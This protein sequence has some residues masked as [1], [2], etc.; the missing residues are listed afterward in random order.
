[1]HIKRIFKYEFWPFWLF[2]IP[3]YCYYFYLAIKAKRWV[4]FS[5]LNTCMDYGGAFLSSKNNYLKFIPKNWMPR[6]VYAQKNDLFEKT[7][8]LLSENNIT[9]PLI[10]KPDMGERGKNVALI[11]SEKELEN[12][13][14][15]IKEPVLIQEYISYPIE[16]GILFFWDTNNKPCISSIGVKKFCEIEGN[17]KDTLEKIVLKNHRIAK[18]K[19]ILK[20]KF[21][22]KWQQII[23]KGEKILIEP[24]G[25]H[26]LGTT[27][28]DGRKYYSEEMLSWVVECVKNIPGF[29]YG[30]LD[31]KI[32]NWSAFRQNRGVKLLEINGV[33]SEP[34]HI[35][36]PNYFILN[37]YKD[38]FYHMKI[39]YLLSKN[40]MD[41]KA[42]TVSLLEFLRGANKVLKKKKIS[43]LLYS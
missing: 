33:N 5:T 30:R 17:G 37:A 7:Q 15:N 34:I 42:P 41:K 38:I 9:F 2:Y 36:D 16:L 14:L 22:P 20:E 32:E 24:I 29:N 6:T 13:L 21:K 1:M 28:Y 27:F 8:K 43:K 18:R 23:P 25:N 3:A 11:Y 26:N 40:K 31:L 19:N 4:Y 39:I 12:Y 35:Y 10:V